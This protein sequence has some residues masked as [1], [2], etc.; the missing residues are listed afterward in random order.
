MHTERVPSLQ[1]TLPDSAATGEANVRAGEAHRLP[2]CIA[3]SLPPQ[4][5]APPFPLGAS[6]ITPGSPHWVAVSERSGSVYPQT[7]G[8]RG[9]EESCLCVYV[10]AR[11]RACVCILCACEHV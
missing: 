10:G 6:H 9:T 8:W 7:R 3:L 11:G 4:P 5:L 1:E 2:A